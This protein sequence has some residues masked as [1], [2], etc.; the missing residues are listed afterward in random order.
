MAT[1]GVLMSVPFIPPSTVGQMRPYAATIPIS[2][3]LAMLGVVPVLA[4]ITKITKRKN[5][6]SLYFLTKT[7]SPRTLL[8]FSVT[9]VIFIFFGPIIIRIV[10]KVP[11][12]V[13]TPCIPGQEAL[14][15]RLNRGSSINLVED[16]AIQSTQLP[17]VGLSEFKNG[18]NLNQP[19]FFKS[20]EPA[21]TFLLELNH[22]A[23]LKNLEAST[24]LIAA[25]SLNS[26][27]KRNYSWLVADSSLIPQQ[28][29]LVKICG[30][31][32]GKSETVFFA[33]SV[34]P[35]SE[36]ALL[37]HNSTTIPDK[38]MV[39]H[40]R[41]AKRFLEINNLDR[42][43]AE[44][45]QI[46]RS[47]TDR[48][49]IITTLGK[50]AQVFLQHHQLDKAVA[51]YTQMLTL[52][53]TCHKGYIRRAQ[54][55][56]QM[57]NLEKAITD[58]TQVISLNESK[59]WYVSWLENFIPGGK[60][61]LIAAYE[62]RA[63]LYQRNNQLDK[64]IADYTQIL[65]LITEVNN[66]VIDTYQKR[67]LLYEKMGLLDKA[68][69]DYSKII[70]LDLRSNRRM[71]IS[72]TRASIYY[73]TEQWDKAISDYSRV[74]EIAG[75]HKKKIIQA[76]TYLGRGQA[77]IHQND[78]QPAIADFTAAIK[79]NPQ[80]AEAYFERGK[81]YWHLNIKDRAE[82]DLHKVLE[83]TDNAQLRQQAQQQLQKI[84]P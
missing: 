80:L 82:V 56:H 29:G 58:Y 22:P 49:E 21:T 26:E 28:L 75:R 53:P 66:K 69:A 79:L 77:Y 74:I 65:A 20:L 60:N 71:A 8:F 52:A 19:A 70:I 4:F 84:E 23:F 1:L 48:Q 78:W 36:T 63:E 43:V 31:A 25:I 38:I 55:Y 61:E 40:Q 15:V 47:S 59:A 81:A 6:N 44:Y 64:A 54:I 41:N 18:L 3:I 10:N 9:L 62:T 50:R 57:D 73:Q 72:K 11:Q 24:T 33:D 67:A 51:D 83:V 5:K 2:A 12:L 34:Q 7:D 16:C 17:V 45:T 37:E 35:V 68:I 27:K 42:A 32:G 13:E 30:K 76:E 39:V 46:I 14:Y